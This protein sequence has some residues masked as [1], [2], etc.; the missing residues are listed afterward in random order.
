M[1][2]YAEEADVGHLE[3]VRSCTSVTPNKV[4]PVVPLEM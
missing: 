4:D 2:R 3:L 1:Q